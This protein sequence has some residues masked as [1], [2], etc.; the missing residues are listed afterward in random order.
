[1]G[2]HLVINALL[3]TEVIVH[4]AVNT[5]ALTISLMKEHNLVSSMSRDGN[6]HDNAVAE[7][8]FA[9]I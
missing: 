8:F 2:K 5:V 1:M 3:K 4:G 7:S 6:C 9:T